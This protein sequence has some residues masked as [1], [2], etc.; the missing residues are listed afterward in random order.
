MCVG[1]RLSETFHLNHGK[2]CVGVRGQVSS[3]LSPGTELLRRFFGLRKTPLS[4][5]VKRL[6]D[7]GWPNCLTRHFSRCVLR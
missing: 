3:F 2:G 1:M 6:V 7:R 4:L 5:S